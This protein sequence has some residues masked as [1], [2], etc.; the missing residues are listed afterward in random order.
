MPLSRKQLCLPTGTIV[1]TVDERFWAKVVEDGD[2]WVW[3][4]SKVDGYGR[5]WPA[6]PKG[7]LAHRWAYESMVGEIPPGLSI[8]HL[9]RRRDCVNPSHLD[10]VTNRENSLR[11][12]NT[13]R[14]G[15]P[16]RNGHPITLDSD[17][18]WRSGA[19]RCL[20]CIRAGY[21]RR[22]PGPPRIHRGPRIVRTGPRPVRISQ[23]ACYLEGCNVLAKS[24]GM[25]LRH[26]HR[27]YGRIRRA[28]AIAIRFA[29]S[30]DVPDTYIDYL[31]EEGFYPD[32]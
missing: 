9:C 25:C 14:T 15:T 12:A 2:C 30:V 10:P 11:G 5:F 18:V 21:I 13:S 24:R 3:T 19:M 20:A 7:V 27:A 1:T 23:V 4:A 31:S 8:D 16:C 17:R 6:G 22:G 28:R 26:Y 29:P 32:E